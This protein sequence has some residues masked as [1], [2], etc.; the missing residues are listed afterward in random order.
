MEQA[1]KKMLTVLSLVLNLV[2]ALN[3]NDRINRKGNE[4]TAAPSQTK[5]CGLLR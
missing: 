2:R 5:R 4:N 3:H 1:D